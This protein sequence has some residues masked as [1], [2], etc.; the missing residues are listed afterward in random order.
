MIQYEFC[1][2]VASLLRGIWIRRIKIAPFIQHGKIYHNLY[3]QHIPYDHKGDFHR[4]G[5]SCLVFGLGL[6]SSSYELHSSMAA[7]CLEFHSTISSMIPSTVTSP[8]SK[9]GGCCCW[10]LDWSS[11]FSL[12]MNDVDMVGEGGGEEVSGWDNI[13]SSSSSF[14]I[15]DMGRVIKSS[16]WWFLT[17]KM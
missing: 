13:S 10:Q 7:C 4:R 14:E 9:S 17:N 8:W 11:L 16:S 1:A 6:V 2:Y 12:D 5:L 15:S 3:F